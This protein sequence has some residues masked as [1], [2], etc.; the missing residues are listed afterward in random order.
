MRQLSVALVFAAA[1]FCAACESDRTA[2]PLLDAPIDLPQA[3]VLTS[4][5]LLPS[6]AELVEQSEFQ[7][8]AVSRNQNGRPMP[9]SSPV[10][11][12]SDAPQVARVSS[13]GFVTGV[14]PGT[15]VITAEI[16]L[17]SLVLKSATTVR[18]RELALSSGAVLYAQSGGWQPNPAIITAGSAVEWK[19][20]MIA[21]SGRTVSK[22]YL[23]DMDYRVTDS[24]DLSSGSATRTFT[25]PGTIRYCSN[26]CWDP[27]EFGII[28]IR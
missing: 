21:V 5:E 11:Y 16:S 20:G 26:A 10:S 3:N 7:L 13:T 6:S 4:L 27:P 1:A 14:S 24:L 2:A 17:G 23:L 8:T 19:A 22:V 25:S 28:T 15:A 18:V 12:S 9:V